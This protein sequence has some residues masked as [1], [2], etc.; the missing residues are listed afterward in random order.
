MRIVSIRSASSPRL[1][2]IRD[3]KVIDMAVAAPSMPKDLLTLLQHGT[4]AL[5]DFQAAAS[6]AP[7]SAC[8]DYDAV[9]FDP[10]ITRPGKV[11]CLGLNYKDHAAEGGHSLPGYPSLFL[12]APTSLI[13]HKR[14]IV[15]PSC[16]E[17]LDYEAE[18]AVIIGATA[19]H[20]AVSDAL[21]FVAGY[22]CFNDASIRDYQR[23]T[24][25]WTIGKNF[26]GTGAFG[27]AFV[28]ADELPPGATGL[29]ISS[30]LNGQVMQENTTANMI[31]PVAETISLLSECMTLE[32]GDVIAMGTP[33]GVGHARKP[34]V[35]M[36]P[37]DTI[38]IDIENIGV[39]SN[40]IA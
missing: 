16:S 22:S 19:R 3:G 38:E 31:F 13:G 34:P 4:T 6:A 24:T 20:V 39:L 7:A 35:W 9:E 17:Q 8:L 15:R 37:G 26:D 18:L 32:P 12:R 27:P 25:Q 1:G 10:L 5:D 21:K 40:P 29:R 36:K 14:A 33:E 11:I 23:K 30:R 2:V 28:T